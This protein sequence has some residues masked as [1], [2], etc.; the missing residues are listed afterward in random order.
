MY[1]LTV[2]VA[3]RWFGLADAN[4]LEAQKVTLDTSVPALVPIPTV[5]YPLPVHRP[6]NSRL[7]TSKVPKA[8]GLT[9]PH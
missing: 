5:H 3:T 9:I 2:S 7:D 1:N 6:A 4:F 8:F